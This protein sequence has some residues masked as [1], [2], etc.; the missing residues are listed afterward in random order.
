MLQ[1]ISDVTHNS[2]IMAP[3]MI[4]MITIE[5]TNFGLFQCFQRLLSSNKIPGAIKKHDH[6]VGKP[7]LVENK[8]MLMNL[9]S[10]KRTALVGEYFYCW[11]FLEKKATSDILSFKWEP[12]SSIDNDFELT[13]LPMTKIG[14]M[15]SRIKRGFHFFLLLERSEEASWGCLF[16][17]VSSCFSYCYFL[18][19]SLD[20]WFRQPRS[21][22]MF[23]F[24][25]RINVGW[26]YSLSS[27]RWRMNSGLNKRIA[28][29]TEGF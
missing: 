26:E 28:T 14:M 16:F 19:F 22:L 3:L 4:D 2:V 6:L 13:G 25:K 17:V 18:F 8:N 24:L 20:F 15:I 21:F 29:P 12:M 7:C 5:P 23:T 1:V 27:C 11:V 9:W 10:A